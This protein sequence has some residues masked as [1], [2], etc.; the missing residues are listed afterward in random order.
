MAN[1]EWGAVFCIQESDRLMAEKLYPYQKEGAM[2]LATQRFGLLA[3]EMGLGKSA[4]AIAATDIIGAKNVLVVCP[5]SVKLNWQ[6]EFKKFS[7][8]A[9]HVVGAK[10]SVKSDI[11]ITNYARVA[12]HLDQY[13]KVVWDAVV[14]DESHYLKEPSSRRAQAVFGKGGLIHMAKRVWCLS[15]TPAPNHAAELWVWLHAYGFTRLSYEGFIDRYC[16]FHKANRYGPPRVLG[17]NKKHIEEVRDALDL[18]SLRRLKR[19]V[20]KDMPSATFSTFHMPQVAYD[21]FTDFPE[22][23]KKVFEELEILKHRL[24]L[25]DLNI[26]SD[27]T[28]EALTLLSPS[29]SSLRRY[30]GLKK[31][32]ACAE[33]IS[34]ELLAGAY[35]KIVLFCVHKDV[36]DILKQ[37][38]RLRGI[39]SV[40]ITGK[41]PQEQRQ[42]NIDLFQHSKDVR[43]FIGNIQAAGTGITLTSAHN[44]AFV[45][46]DWVPGNNRQAADRVH[47]IGQTLPVNVRFFSLPGIDE[48]I[49]STLARKTAEISTFITH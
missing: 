49:A 39:N 35:K 4:Q 45:E 42:K 20:L 2:W 46:Y 25:H 40:A 11:I 31:A 36:A 44:L 7:G 48:H 23:E 13:A 26:D 6:R 34:S 22:L 18:C 37:C 27:K 19:K 12:R 17:T 9:A 29:V 28:L 24:G 5:A 14:F 30:H 32:K 47:R 10:D 21:P 41:T 33:V 16:T 1:A 15:G 43:V 38:F 8:K 3:D